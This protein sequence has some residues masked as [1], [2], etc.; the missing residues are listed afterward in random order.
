MR[1]RD[2]ILKQKKKEEEEVVY[3]PEFKA[4]RALFSQ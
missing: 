3:R 2:R 4:F 1:V